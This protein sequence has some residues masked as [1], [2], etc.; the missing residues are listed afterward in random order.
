MIWLPRQTKRSSYELRKL[1]GR[2]FDGAWENNINRIKGEAE[3]MKA[4]KDLSKLLEKCP[5]VY[6]IHFPER[7]DR[8]TGKKWKE[9]IGIVKVTNVDK[10]NERPFWIVEALDGAGS[11]H[12]LNKKDP[13]NQRNFSVPLSVAWTGKVIEE[14]YEQYPDRLIFANKFA[15]ALG[16][17]CDRFKNR[18]NRGEKQGNKGEVITV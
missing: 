11:L 6:M 16:A 12:W 17:A 7:E 5:G 9:G 1:I 3:K 15:K 8:K 4:N 14:K 18:S 10:T 13:Y 2:Y